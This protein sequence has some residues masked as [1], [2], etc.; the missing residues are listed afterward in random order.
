MSDAISEPVPFP[1]V[2]G[3]TGHRDIDPNARHRIEASVRAVLTGF[4]AE[5]GVALHVMTALADGADQLVATIASQMGISI[6]A[7]SPMEIERYYETVKDKH[8]LK[9]YWCDA[10]LQIQL[11][12]VCDPAERG[13]E[14]YNIQHY[15]QLAAFL[16][17]RS[18]ILLALWEGP[19]HTADDNGPPRPGGT[20][21]V[22][23]L[24]FD[25]R[26]MKDRASNSRLFARSLSFLDAPQAEPVVH[27][28]TPRQK[29]E[30]VSDTI[31]CA[32]PPAGRCFL[33]HDWQGK[34][35]T[36]VTLPHTIMASFN[37]G[38]RA[39]FAEIEILNQIILNLPNSDLGTFTN[40]IS[41]IDIEGVA[42]PVGK[43][44][45]W[46]RRLQAGTD[47]AAIEHQ[48]RLLGHFVG[49]K[50]RDIP[51][52]A[53]ETWLG[54]G[55]RAMP[56]L[57]LWFTVVVPIAVGM[58]EWYAHLDGGLVAIIAY[59]I[60]L[61]TPFWYYNQFVKRHQWQ[62][63]FENYRALAEALRVQ[64][65]WSVA[66]MPIAATDNYLRKQMGELGWIQFALRGPA[67]WATSLALRLG[68]PQL[69][70]IKKGWLLNQVEYFIGGDRKSGKSQANHHAARRNRLLAKISLFAGFAVTVMLI[71]LE[72]L[73]PAAELSHA[74]AHSTFLLSIECRHYLTV[75]A[76]ILPAIAAFLTVST[77]LRAYESHARNYWHM[78]QIFD[79]ALQR[80]MVTPPL[81]DAAV[82]E[83]LHDLGREALAENVEWLMDHRDR[84][85]E[86]AG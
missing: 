53:V 50:I 56:S 60:S 84:P 12:E 75:I 81:D 28:V 57:L 58:F 35:S 65:Y 7:V 76:A 59:L 17:R 13:T 79:R 73:L 9:Q 19:E 24:R 42:D 67:L 44:L 2:V 66:A 74:H 20:V 83:L 71:G 37:P 62:S 49:R 78:G 34:F 68:V 27:I 40:H 33:L 32:G 29:K 5:F 21:D 64:L 16:A 52:G 39:A 41:Y 82:Q 10:K 80:T 69:E 51:G 8:T 23:R 48:R 85:V 43:P 72:V 38:V 25:V 77:N 14:A 36:D 6:V 70:T 1:I 31:D 86:P 55:P 26:Y 61:S 47:A 15:I 45:H 54:S 4:R 11:P 18:H 22:L 30:P 3:V 63:R 46:L